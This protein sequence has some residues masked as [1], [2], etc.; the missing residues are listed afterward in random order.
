MW[1]RHIYRKEEGKSR[2]FC[3]GCN[4]ATRRALGCKGVFYKNQYVCVPVPSK[5]YLS[6][7]NGSLPIK[8]IFISHRETPMKQ[9]HWFFRFFRG[10]FKYIKKGSSLYSFPP[11]TPNQMFCLPKTSFCNGDS[12]NKL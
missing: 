9:P 5:L 3:E 1:C 2:P 12:F 7:S 4:N 8:D 10:V 11:S 6:L